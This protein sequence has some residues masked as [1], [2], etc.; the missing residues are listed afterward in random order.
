MT[1]AKTYYFKSAMHVYSAELVRSTGVS[2]FQTFRLVFLLHIK[3][4]A[5]TR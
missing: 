4:A 5:F 3:E 1:V 2:G